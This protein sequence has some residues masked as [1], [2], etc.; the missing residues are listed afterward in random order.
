MSFEAHLAAEIDRRDGELFGE[1]KEA[2]GEVWAEAGGEAGGQIESAE[3]WRQARPHLVRAL[4]V[5]LQINANAKEH[6]PS[7]PV[8]DLSG[9]ARVIISHLVCLMDYLRDEGY[10]SDTEDGEEGR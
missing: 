6:N 9:E 3:F 5:A 10:L 8:Y 2:V 1:V 4:A 7:S